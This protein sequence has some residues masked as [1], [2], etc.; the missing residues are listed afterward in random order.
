MIPSRQSE[1]DAALYPRRYYAAVRRTGDKP[2]TLYLIAKRIFDIA[3]S[4]VALI[5]LSPLFLILALAI[6]LEDPRGSVFFGQT[7]V[8]L[9]GKHFRMFKFRSMISNA[10]ALLPS[11]LAQ[12]EV[13]GPMFKM[14]NDPRVTRVGRFIRRT[15]IDELPQLLNVLKGEMSLVGPRPS[16]PHEVERY[17]EYDRLRLTVTPGCTGLWQVSGRSGLDFAQ[18]VEL[19]LMYIEQRSLLLD[20]KIM[21]MT[22]WQLVRSNNAY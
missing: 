8:G 9:E 21:F 16:L 17:S 10:E 14:R 13:S 4:A 19:D 18:M 3:A 1:E 11:L 22:A 15:S 2:V 5:V 20:L 7:R 12:N 6:K